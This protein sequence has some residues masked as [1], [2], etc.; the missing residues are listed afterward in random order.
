L[1][2]RDNRE[3]ISSTGQSREKAVLASTQFEA[4][5]FGIFLGVNSEREK[6]RSPQCYRHFGDGTLCI[7][8]FCRPFFHSRAEQGDG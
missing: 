4:S 6:L 1:Q 3:T 2:Y 8:I 7:D 5:W